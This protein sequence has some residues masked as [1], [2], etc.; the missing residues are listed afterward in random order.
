MARQKRK[1]QRLD[2]TRLTSLVRQPMWAR[3]QARSQTLLVGVTLSFLVLLGATAYVQHVSG[4]ESLYIAEHNITSQHLL[5]PARGLFYDRDGN[6]LVV[7]KESYSL[8]VNKGDY[9]TDRLQQ[10]L[11]LV[12]KVKEVDIN[13]VTE[14]FTA[15]DDTQVLL[16]AGI[17]NPQRIAMID[18]LQ[19]YPHYLVS[20]AVREYLYPE[21]FS[22]I[23]GY[24]GSATAEDVANG[25]GARD[26]VGRYRLEQSLDL[27]LRGLKGRATTLGVTTQVIP[28][29]PGEN[30]FLTIDKDW[31]NKLYEILG[32]Q[33]AWTG[34]LSGAAVI[35]DSSNG[36]VLAS[37]GYPSFDA[38]LF[39]TG[40]SVDEYQALLNDGRKPLVDK[41]ISSQASPGSSFKF[42]TAYGLLQN[43]TID[44]N[45]HYFSTGCMQI[46][47]G[48]PFCEY[49]KYYLGDLDIKRALTRSSNIFF[50]ESILKL[51]N[52][53]GYEKFADAISQLG[54]GSSTGIN[55]GGEVSG[56]LASPAFKQEAYGQN[57]FG[58]DACNA[59]IGQG[60]TLVTPLQL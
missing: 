50:C 58:G 43:G 47:S 31:Q 36:N 41:V 46:S 18:L 45:T 14:K 3:V 30:V 34:A 9:D 20:D 16:L 57:W 53:I 38:N 21:S 25:Y 28:E 54:V 10:L 40:I 19:D 23:L 4:A 12:G 35:L 37:I 52:E 5:N 1:V 2:I 15:T 56:V 49:G 6:V 60:F 39:S 24:T 29:L 59:V 55:L 17:T 32:E 27:E 42:I 51:S 26:I 44:E 22:H 8:I 11:S 13:A 33:V 48:F 7:N